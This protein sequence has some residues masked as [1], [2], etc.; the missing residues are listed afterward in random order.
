[1]TSV[2]ST[3]AVRAHIHEGWKSYFDQKSSFQPINLKVFSI[4]IES[5]KRHSNDWKHTPAKKVIWKKI[6]SQN[7]SF[8]YAYTLY[9]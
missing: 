1:M 4:V 7:I 3:Y 8:E 9:N 5:L 6:F 2:E